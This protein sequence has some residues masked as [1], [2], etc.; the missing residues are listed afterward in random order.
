MLTLALGAVERV[1]G[2]DSELAELWSDGTSLN[3]W[4]ATLADIEERLRSGN[5][6]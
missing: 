1:R 2:K 3:E 6:N 4:L 5:A